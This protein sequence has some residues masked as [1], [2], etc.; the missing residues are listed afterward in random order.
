LNPHQLDGHAHG[1][2]DKKMVARHVD[3]RPQGSFVNYVLVAKEGHMVGI[4]RV[5]KQVVGSHSIV[6]TT[7]SRAD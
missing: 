4:L 6:A 3:D 2:C 1:M 5:D 7:K